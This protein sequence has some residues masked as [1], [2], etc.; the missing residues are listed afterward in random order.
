MEEEI[1]MEPPL[2]FAPNGLHIWTTHF[3]PQQ[4]VIATTLINGYIQMYSF[5]SFRLKYSSDDVVPLVTIT[6]AHRSSARHC[7]FNMSGN[8]KYE[9]K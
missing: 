3:H 9:S 5:I 1:V 4:D 7:R 6:D 8:S 2:Y